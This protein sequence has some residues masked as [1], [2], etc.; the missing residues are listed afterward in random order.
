M[1]RII[2]RTFAKIGVLINFLRV[3]ELVQQIR[4]FNSTHA[5]ES[6]LVPVLAAA[7]LNFAFATA[8]ALPSNILP[9]I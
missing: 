4:Q 5:F 8:P 3:F 6:S 7:A 9:N 2:K 1:R